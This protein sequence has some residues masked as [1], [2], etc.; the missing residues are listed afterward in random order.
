[1]CQAVSA[2]YHD[3][4]TSRDLYMLTW[5][6]RVRNTPWPRPDRVV[7]IHNGELEILGD[8][9]PLG[10]VLNHVYSFDLGQGPQLF[11]VGDFS[12]A[13]GGVEAAGIAR[14]DGQRWSAVGPIVPGQRAVVHGAVVWDE[15]GAGPL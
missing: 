14:W 5:S 10:S 3:D 8:D 1:S 11:A 15:D 9:F 2:V 4:G 7:R 6:M 12:R 13:P